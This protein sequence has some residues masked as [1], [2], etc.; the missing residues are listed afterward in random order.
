MTPSSL[1]NLAAYGGQLLVVVA[2]AAIALRLVRLPHAGARLAYWQT[3]VA[4]CLALPWLPRPALPAAP[5]GAMVTTSEVMAAVVAVDT[6]VADGVSASIALAVAVVI[7]LGVLLR[8]A[9]LALGFLRL[10]TLRRQG[11]RAAMSDDVDVLRQGLAPRAELLWNDT[12][13]QPATFGWRCP[14][15]LLPAAFAGL[16]PRAQRAV[17]CHE[18]LHAARGDWAWRVVEEIVCCLFWFHPAMRWAVGQVQ[19][20]RE[21]VVDE[22]VVAITSVRRPYMKALVE[23]ASVSGQAV[24]AVPFVARRHLAS[25][26]ARLAEE[27]TMT[28]RGL[29]FSGLLLAAMLVMSAWAAA[30]ALPL[31]DEGTGDELTTASAVAPGSTVQPAPP[32][33][34]PPPAPDSSVAATTDR[35]ATL[36]LES[37]A[38]RDRRAFAQSVAASSTRATAAQSDEPLKVGGNIRPP[39]KIYNVSP[40]YP[41]DAQAAGIQGVV[42][43]EIIIDKE[44]N[45]RDVEVVRSIP[46]LD[47]AAVD[48]VW[49]WMYEPTLLNGAP[50]EVA[51]TVTVNFT[52][53]Q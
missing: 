51:M 43:M 45:V 33:P 15:I 22:K 38:R 16:D 35:V 9:W 20:S 10:H 32:P 24:P 12:L 5:A 6:A 8:G 25:R 48:A 26:I 14:I 36:T 41:A 7:A 46:E 3:V 34:P 30:S 37:A 4:I 21:E 50:V 31:R 18:L 47:Q 49:Q 52:L 19:L 40:I 27:R 23:F 1:W 39:R 29:T 11:R 53:T 44:G 28:R 42:I 2:V 13:G 17:V